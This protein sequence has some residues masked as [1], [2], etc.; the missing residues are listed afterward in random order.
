MP[1]GIPL[2]E[3]LIPVPKVVT[4]PGVLVTVQFPAEG[5]SSSTT[6]PVDNIQVGCVMLPTVGAV[7]T[8]GAVLITT[9]ADAAELHPAVF[10]TEKVYEP[11]GIPVTV[12]L[13]PVPTIVVVGGKLVNVQEPVAGKPFIIT[14]PVATVHV[15]CTIDPTVGIFGVAG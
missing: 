12:L 4:A 9:F 13:V 11:D 6:R 5:K 8:R 15:G 10:A 14:L 7:G 1:V 2:I 3:A